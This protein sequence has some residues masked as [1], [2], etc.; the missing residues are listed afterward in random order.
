DFRRF[1]DPTNLLGGGDDEGEPVGE[2]ASGR[3]YETPRFEAARWSF[4]ASGLVLVGPG[5]YQLLAS[6]RG[7]QGHPLPYFRQVVRERAGTAYVQLTDRP[8]T[9]RTDDLLT[10]DAAVQKEFYLGDASFSL[11]LQALKLLNEDTVLERELDLGTGRAGFADE[12]L[13]S[14]TLRVELR[15]WWR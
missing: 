15:F 12:T 4:G 3:P 2:I 9:F 6:V 1:D 11:S 5:E 10:V 8:D 14:R 7:R 13:S